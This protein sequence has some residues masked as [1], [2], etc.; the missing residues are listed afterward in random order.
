MAKRRKKKSQVRSQKKASE[1]KKNRTRNL[2]IGIGAAVAAVIV[3]FVLSGHMPFT[4]KE[5]KKGRSF[6]VQG[7]ETRPILDPSMFS[8]RTK[9]AYAAAKKYP[10]VLDQVF[11]YCTCDQ[12]P[13]NHKSLLSCFT[14]NHGAG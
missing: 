6:Y 13:V 14:D 8:G 12:P 10:E 3:F 9:A 11:C 4:Q 1:A 5:S 2:F 7:G